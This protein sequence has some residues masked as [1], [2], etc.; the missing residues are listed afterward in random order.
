MFSYISHLNKYK[1]VS[2]NANSIDRKID[3]ENLVPFS[4]G[5]KTLMKNLGSEYK[6]RPKEIIFVQPEH[7]L[8]S[9]YCPRALCM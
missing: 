6:L 5:N 4:F 2:Q 9:R 1:R 3:P 8:S 7:C